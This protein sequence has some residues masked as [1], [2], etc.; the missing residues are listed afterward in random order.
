MQNKNNTEKV[1]DAMNYGSPLNQIVILTAIEKYC[2]Q[3]SK[4]EEKPENW[5]DLISWKSWQ[6]SCKDVMQRAFGEK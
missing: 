6:E 1:H 3:V 4:I 5:G 2:E